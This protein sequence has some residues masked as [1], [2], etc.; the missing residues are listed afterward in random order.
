MGIRIVW[1]AADRQAVY[2]RFVVVAKEVGTVTTGWIRSNVGRVSLEALGE[3]LQRFYLSVSE[4]QEILEFI[5]SHPSMQPELD[6]GA[7]GRMKAADVI[8]R[9]QELE[10]RAQELNEKLRERSDLETRAQLYKEEWGSTVWEDARRYR[11]QLSKTSVN[12]VISA[13]TPKQPRKFVVILGVHSKHRHSIQQQHP[14]ISFCWIDNHES[15]A[16]IIRKVAGN[17]AIMH[18]HGASPPMWKTVRINAKVSH[19]INGLDRLS[20]ILATV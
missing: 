4:T 3:G 10:R 17:V 7:Y 18:H 13:P 2:N 8:A 11:G 16:Q 6:L 12:K 20:A 1:S 9:F 14:H 15:D 19:S 5:Q